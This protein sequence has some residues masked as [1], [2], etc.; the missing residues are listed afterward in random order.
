MFDLPDVSVDDL[1]SIADWVELCA[2]FSKQGEMSQLACSD[3][4]IDKG[5]LGPDAH[6]YFDDDT[7]YADDAVLSDDDAVDRFGELVWSQLSDRQTQ[8]GEGYPFRVDSD[9]LTRRADHWDRTV[10]Y[11]TLLLA[12]FSRRYKREVEKN[13][14]KT[15]K[16]SI[17]TGS[18]FPPLFEKVVEASLHGVLGGRS[19]RF[20]WPREPGWPKS[21]NARVKRLANAL[22]LD[23]ETLE[24]KTGTHDK[25]MGLDVVA[26]LALGDDESGSMYVLTQCA[27]GRNWRTKT[28]EPALARWRD[29]LQWKA[30][31]VRAI[32]IPWRLDADRDYWKATRLFDDAIIMDRPRLAYGQPDKHLAGETRKKLRRWCLVQRRRLPRHEGAS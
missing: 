26:R 3:V 18:G 2:L 21:I 7:T 25:D 5:M 14:S 22:E 4:F 16:I 28:G 23:T 32:A 27:T 13:Q 10:A 24:G 19:V 29:L 30:R 20:G 17:E 1:A 8:L 6:D 11:A 9:L 15:R 12:D 31:L